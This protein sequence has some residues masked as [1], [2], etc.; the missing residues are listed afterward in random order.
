MALWLGTAINSTETAM[1]FNRLVNL[2]ALPMIRRKNGL[3]YKLMGKADIGVNTKAMSTFERTDII[4]GKNY[5]V[6]LLGALSSTTKVTDGASEYAAV[7]LS[8]NAN[9]YGAAEFPLTHYTLSKAVPASQLRR[10]K[11]KFAKT[12]DFYKEV[13]TEI[14]LS[15]ENDLGNDLHST[16]GSTV[17]GRT[18]FGSWAFAVSTGGGDSG[19]DATG[20]TA[21]AF[22]NYG[23][24][25]R[26]D[27]A[28]VDFRGIVQAASGP[29]TLAAFRLN[30]NLCDAKGGKI[31][32]A[33]AE[34]TLYTKAQMLLEPYTYITDAPDMVQFGG[35]YMR[36][37]GVDWI[38]DQRC[39]VG[40]IGGLDSSTWLFVKS[41]DALTDVGLVKDPSRVDTY[42]LPT[43]L[44][45]QLI[46]KKPNGNFKMLGVT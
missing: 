18:V 35:R 11:G 22:R 31:D 40:T 13:L 9:A 1:V 3:L 34:T 45:S 21:V 29:L 17:I 23:T 16:V 27:P 44:W 28:N 8:Y 39:P 36:Y 32:T 7:T 33:V 14:M 37:D 46:C 10:Y 38:H 19:I 24:I 42:V 12:D 43:A 41:D 30:V 5:E 20:E 15:Y 2:Q 26:Q 6:R 25:D 4:D